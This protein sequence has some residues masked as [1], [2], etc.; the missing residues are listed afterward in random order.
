LR[1]TTLWSTAANINDLQYSYHTQHNRRVRM[2]D[3]K[4]IDFSNMGDEII[5]LELDENKEQDIEEIKL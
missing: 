5:Y 3:L 2:I 1:S 4:E